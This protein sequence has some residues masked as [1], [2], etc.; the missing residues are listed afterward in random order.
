MN[1]TGVI[2]AQ[3]RAILLIAF[4]LAAAVWSPTATGIA[5]TTPSN[6]AET[7]PAET[8][9]PCWTRASRLAP[10]VCTAVSAWATWSRVASCCANS[11]LA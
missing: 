2:E 8:P 7:A 10:A 11:W 4:A 6:G 5:T 3:W 9:A 1:V